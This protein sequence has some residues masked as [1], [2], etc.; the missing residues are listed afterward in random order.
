MRKTISFF[1]YIFHPIV[2]PTLA[3]L[4]YFLDAYVFFQP[5]EIS[6]TIGQVVVTT[7]L[8]PTAIYFLLHSLHA[9][10]SS[11][12]VHNKKERITPFLIQIG[13]LFLLKNYILQANNV[14]EFNL[15]IWGL[16]Y[17]YIG[18]TICLLFGKKLSVHVANITALLAF[19]VLFSLH[20]YEAHL[21]GTILLIFALGLTATSRLF[22]KAHTTKEVIG[23]FLLGLIPQLILWTIIAL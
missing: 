19:Y 1:S 8:I 13:L 22:L 7:F 2:I 18:L 5:L 16:M 11:I 20:F 15:F 6:I 17:T 21:I 12:M 3:I 23:G 10:K 9:L 4:L 14:Y